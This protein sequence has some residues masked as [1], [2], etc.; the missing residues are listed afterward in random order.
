MLSNWLCFALHRRAYTHT[1]Y[2]RESCG[3][4][5]VSYST[6]EV[7]EQTLYLTGFVGK[8]ADIGFIIYPENRWWNGGVFDMELEIQ[9]WKRLGVGK[10][11][12][13]MI[14][15]IEKAA[16]FVSLLFAGMNRSTWIYVYILA[17]LYTSENF[18]VCCYRK[19]YMLRFSVSYKVKMQISKTET[20]IHLP[21]VITSRNVLLT[22]ML[23]VVCKQCTKTMLHACVYIIIWHLH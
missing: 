2:R 21:C 6:R 4:Y 23:H 9:I 3:G 7:L 20:Y 5:K 15:N 1:C 17:S 16:I 8:T 11:S 12:T 10:I 22:L 13:Y 18:S 19:I 14:S